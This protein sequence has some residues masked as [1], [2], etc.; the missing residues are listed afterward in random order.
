M[1]HSNRNKQVS[2]LL[3][4]SL[5]PFSQ[6]L[7]ELDWKEALSEDKERLKE[8]LSAFANRSGGGYIVFGIKDSAEVLGIADTEGKLIISKLGS[9]AREGIEPIIQ[10]EHFPFEFRGR[11]LLIVYIPES[12]E[13]PVHKR[14][15]SI[16]FSYIR[17]G[18]QTRKMSNQELRLSLLTSRSLR[19]EELPASL[20]FNLTTNLTEH[21]DFKEVFLRMRRPSSVEAKDDLEFLHSLKLLAHSQGKFSPTN[22]GVLVAAKDLSQLPHY[23]RYG[24]RLTVYEGTSRLFARKEEDFNDGYSLSLDR[25]ITSVMR[26]L[27]INE[28]F[29][30]ATRNEIPLIPEKALREVIG[31]AIVHRDYTKTTSYTTVEIF[32]DRVEITNPGGLV[33]ELPLDRLID[34]PSRTRNEV[35]ADLMKKLNF[36]EERGSGI[37]RAV[38]AMEYHGLPPIKFV[39]T[40]DYFKAVLFAPKDFKDMEK[41]ERIDAVY[42]HACLNSVNSKKTTNAS[43]RQRFKFDDHQ[44][45]KVSRLLS[46][47][48][49]MKRIKVANPKASPRDLHYLP[50]WG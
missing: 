17:S 26:I 22:L 29:K 35:L 31:N 5:G 15:K 11:E 7:N 45:T 12:I 13:K 38:E 46:D 23:E 9:L 34:F 47:A 50:Y 44:S 28:V 8:H 24:I 42:Q 18:G 32:R 10:V 20:E 4:L 39:S 40:P 16:E 27:P 2:D 36:C 41:E 6:E 25:L 14:G 30:R 33:P 43:I 3:S 19:F 21:F 1:N 48:L 37:D 49:E